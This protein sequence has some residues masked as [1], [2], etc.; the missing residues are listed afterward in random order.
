[1]RGQQLTRAF[2]G[3]GGKVGTNLD[4]RRFRAN[5][6]LDLRNKTGFAEDNFVGRTLRIGN[7]AVIAVLDCDPRCKMITLDP[8]NGNAN[9]EVMRVLARK[10]E[11]KAGLYGAVLVEG[12]IQNGDPVSVAMQQSK[13]TRSRNTGCQDS[14]ASDLSMQHPEIC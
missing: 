12:T 13:R 4:L 6:Y 2:A 3:F 8:D 10:H 1:M 9:P 5:I 14:A 11:E 7:Q